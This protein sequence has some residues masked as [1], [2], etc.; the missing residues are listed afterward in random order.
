MNVRTVSVEMLKII[1][2]GAVLVGLLLTQPAVAQKAQS[3]AQKTAKSVPAEI[4]K[5]LPG[6]SL[7]PISKAQCSWGVA[8]IN[9]ETD[10]VGHMERGDVT[11]AS[12]RW[13]KPPAET[14]DSFVK[15]ILST[16]EKHETEF[17]IAMLEDQPTKRAKEFER[18]RM[19]LSEEQSLLAYIL[20]LRGCSISREDMRFAK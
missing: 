19:E 10:A 1:A 20:E 9:H 8:L 2:G 17:M 6:L 14:L 7:G 4:S 18:L 16:M 5:T 12:A 11:D 13:P 15:F 3:S